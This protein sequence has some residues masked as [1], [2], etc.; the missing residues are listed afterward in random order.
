MTTTNR[1]FV[2]STKDI[3]DLRKTVENQ[4]VLLQQHQEEIGRLNDTIKSQNEKYLYLLECNSKLYIRLQNLEKQ[5]L[6]KYD[7]INEDKENDAHKENQIAKKKHKEKES[8]KE[9]KNGNEEQQL[10]PLENPLE[11]ISEVQRLL[12]DHPSYAR[13][14]E[15]IAKNLQKKKKDE[16][17]EESESENNRRKHRKGY[18]NHHHHN[19]DVVEKITVERKIYKKHNPRDYLSSTI[20]DTLN[21]FDIFPLNNDD[22]NRRRRHNRRNHSPNTPSI[23]QV[24]SSSSSSS[25]PDDDD[26]YVEE[27]E[28]YTHSQID[29]HQRRRKINHDYVGEVTTMPDHFSDDVDMSS[30][31]ERSLPR[32]PPRNDK[33]RR[34]RVGNR[35]RNRRY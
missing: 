18:G 7:P 13:D 24:T 21:K 29:N 26:T 25:S 35:L 34:Q 11:T 28:Q 17:E 14:I 4:A 5:M 32:S 22:R 16:F 30:D 33:P 3:M 20:D 1:I 10:L 31:S 15:N 8:K 23:K 9:L 12:N 2:G 19:H 27:S 6:T